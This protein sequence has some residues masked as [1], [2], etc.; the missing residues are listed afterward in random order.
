MLK[1][2]FLIQPQIAMSARDQYRQQGVP[3]STATSTGLS[4]AAHP[5]VNTNGQYGHSQSTAAPT[6]SQQQAVAAS[7]GQYTYP[8][9]A[10]PAN[11]HYGQ[12]QAVATSNGQYIH[13]Q[14][15]SP[16]NGHHS[17]QPVAAAPSYGMQQ[18]LQQPSYEGP[19]SSYNRRDYEA[20]CRPNG[21]G[22]NGH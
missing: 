6:Y 18:W 14:S 13:P 11:G 22:Q 15:A 1:V 20:C 12:Q 9:T 8:Q 16:V 17:Q 5:R 10:P 19:W 4:S 3:S 7:T 2:D 21:P